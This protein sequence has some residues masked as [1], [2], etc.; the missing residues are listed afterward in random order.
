MSTKVVNIVEIF[1]PSYDISEF[2]N[3]DI[4]GKEV[5]GNKITGI[6][7]NKVFIETR[8]ISC[9]DWFFTIIQKYPTLNFVLKYNDE[10]YQYFYGWAVACKGYLISCDEINGLK[11][12][13]SDNIE[14]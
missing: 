11:F 9:I 13:H 6:K 2:V 4:F 12:A 8:L 1:G 7:N 5:I 14:V 3:K 10:Y